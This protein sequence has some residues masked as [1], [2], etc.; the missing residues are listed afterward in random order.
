MEWSST[1]GWDNLI[2]LQGTCKAK[3]EREKGPSQKRAWSWITSACSNCGFGYFCCI[4]MTVDLEPLKEYDLLLLHV[5]FMSVCEC[6]PRGRNG[7]ILKKWW[8]FRYNTHQ[9][10]Y[11]NSW[12]YGVYFLLHEGPMSLFPLSSPN[13]V[14]AGHHFFHPPLGGPSVDAGSSIFRCAL[15]TRWGRSFGLMTQ[16]SHSTSNSKSQ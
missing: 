10:G 9:N 15:R 11:Q 5:F 3:G 16:P 1:F 6:F 8:F 4:F 12:V 13:N 2:C 14:V 7:G